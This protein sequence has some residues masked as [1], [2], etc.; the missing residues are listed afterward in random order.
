[1]LQ[2]SP[3]LTAL[4]HVIAEDPEAILVSPGPR[5]RAGGHV[6]SLVVGS[7]VKVRFGGGFSQGV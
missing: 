5:Y 1:M 7:E 6:F 3:T 2:V 4:D